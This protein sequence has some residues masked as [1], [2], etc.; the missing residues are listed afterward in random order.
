VTSSTTHPAFA[1][2]FHQLFDKY[3]H[4]YQYPM[5]D[6][7]VRGYKWKLATR[8]DNSFQFLLMKSHDALQRYATERSEFLSWLAGLVDSDGHIRIGNNSG[9]TRICL[10]IGS[11][12]Q[13]FLGRFG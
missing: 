13:I 11:T 9:F 6:G 2:L 3:G 10:E 7:G 12:N 8:L 1:D 4:V 5:Y